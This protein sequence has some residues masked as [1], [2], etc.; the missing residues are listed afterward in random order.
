MSTI[1]ERIQKNEDDCLDNPSILS[2]YI[3][4][5]SS[6]ILEAEKQ[7]TMAEVMY[8]HKWIE[9]RK[10]VK[11]DNSADMEMKL[12]PEFIELR[13]KEAMCKTLI[14]TIRSAKRRLTFLAVEYHEITS[15]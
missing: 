13:S 14:E 3:L 2:E 4:K 6:H 10:V 1:L 12:E 7:K 15:N 11:S 5:L 8:T 9:K